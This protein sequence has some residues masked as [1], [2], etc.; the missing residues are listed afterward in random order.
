[1]GRR[2]LTVCLV[3]A[4]FINAESYHHD[5][6]SLKSATYF[7]LFL[8]SENP[9]VALANEFLTFSQK[10]K[11]KKGVNEEKFLHTVFNKTHQ[12]F[13]KHYSTTATFKQLAEGR[14]NC[15]T[16][17]ALFGILLTDLG[18]QFKIIETNY[19]IFI[20][21]QTSD[22][23]VLIETTDPIKGFVT[24]PASI[25]TRIARYKENEIQDEQKAGKRIYAYNFNLFNEVTMDEMPG[26]LHYNNAVQLFNEQK[27]DG[28]IDELGKAMRY[29]QS[30]RTEEFSKLIIVAI[31]QGKMDCQLKE[32]YLRQIQAIGRQI[33]SAS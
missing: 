3:F 26:L 2:L 13:L 21:V 14:F 20:L 29:Y 31:Q 8:D 18:Y 10:L 24:D 1:M 30:P 28:A 15:L 11:N 5:R 25:E 16:G 6:A 7:F 17:T 12:R 22:G 27:L 9:D 4:A 19:H 33:K 23:V 32:T